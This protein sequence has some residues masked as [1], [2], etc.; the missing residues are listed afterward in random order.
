[1]HAR[2]SPAASP[3]LIRNHLGAALTAALALSLA[4]CQATG[5]LAPSQTAQAPAKNEAV[6]T[7]TTADARLRHDAPADAA[8]AAEPAAKA[9]ADRA[10]LGA[11]TMTKPAGSVE[12]KSIASSP[13][14]HAAPREQS[15]DRV[16]VTGS[17]I[18]P[19]YAKR[20]AM[21]AAVA[22]AAPGFLAPPPPPPAPPYSQPANTEKYAQREDNPVQRT[23]EQ[24]L[25]TFSI[26]V[27]TGSYTNVRRML[28]DGQ[29]PPADA[30][31]AEEFINYFDY[32]HA[33]PTSL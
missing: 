13:A 33:A 18:G 22:A 8:A 19:T 26:D 20:M 27:D 32:G 23:R 31:R 25:S 24:P 15:R 28:N 6:G 7:D 10:N 14:N 2:T 29:R 12:A 5:D 9:E 1:M 17:R 3:R 30:V 4:A 11:A 21:P 16:Q